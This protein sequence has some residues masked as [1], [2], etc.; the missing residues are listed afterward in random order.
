MIVSVGEST[1]SSLPSL[2]D[3]S[4]GDG[5]LFGAVGDGSSLNWDEDPGGRRGKGY[6]ALAGGSSRIM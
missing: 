5:A 4:E 3:T 2:G 1:S 6:R